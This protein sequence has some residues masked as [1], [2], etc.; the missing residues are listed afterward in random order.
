MGKRKTFGK[1]RI[2]PKGPGEKEI[3]LEETK[4][5]FSPRDWR[6]KKRP[7]N[8]EGGF[9][10]EEIKYIFGED[11]HDQYNYTEKCGKGGGRGNSKLEVP[12]G[13]KGS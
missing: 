2:K 8:G 10:L 6:G 13:I 4:W 9:S 5:G 7:N 11:L 12:L 1:T 3:R